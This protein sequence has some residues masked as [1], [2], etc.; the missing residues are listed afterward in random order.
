MHCKEMGEPVE[1]NTRKCIANDCC[2]KEMI[3]IYIGTHDCSPRIKT[4]KPEKKEL[5]EYLKVRPT[6]TVKQIQINNVREALL[7]GK[8]KE[9]MDNMAIRYSDQR[10]IKYL[11]Y[12]ID[13]DIRPERSDIE[14]VRSLSDKL[15]ERNL[16]KNLIL[17]VG[18]NHVILSSEEKI[19]LW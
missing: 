17:E 10:H 6:S 14:P 8:S 3:V 18:E 1:C 19:W 7:S 13:K 16:N 15:A 11:K 12:S 5:E 2:H 9:E 4:L